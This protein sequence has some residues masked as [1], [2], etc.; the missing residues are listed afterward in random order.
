MTALYDQ[1]LTFLEEL[2]DMYPEDPDFR[3]WITGIRLL[4]NTNPSM[5]IKY[6]YDNMSLYDEKIMNKDINFFIEND[7]S[8]YSGY[9]NMDI[10]GKLKG[11]IK[12]MSHESTENVWKYC[13]NVYRLA[14][15]Y[16][17]LA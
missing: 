7:F 12:N 11:Y 15:G 2:S 4:K 10:F 16:Y 3:M 5:L 17:A 9:I 14:K 6:I 13:Q 8:E 1:F